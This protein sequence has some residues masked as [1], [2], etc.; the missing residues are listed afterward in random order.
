MK[1]FVVT[2]LREDVDQSARSE[3]FLNR[4]SAKIRVSELRAD[5][6]DHRLRGDE[7][8]YFLIEPI[9]KMIDIPCNARGLTDAIEGK[10]WRYEVPA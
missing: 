1:M 4:R 3:V 6:E 10:W 8:D 5:A 2:Y 7:G 9:L